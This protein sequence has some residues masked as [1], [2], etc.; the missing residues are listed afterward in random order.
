M[1]RASAL[2]ATQTPLELHP[3]DADQRNLSLG[4]IAGAGDA[5]NALGTGASNALGAALGFHVP[6]RW[7]TRVLPCE[8]TRTVR[9][10]RKRPRSISAAP[11]QFTRSPLR[12][13]SLEATPW[14]RPGRA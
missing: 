3:A 9:R 12:G 13:T 11:V 14:G 1:R 6:S 5:G 2:N 10:I 4:K 7:L 8:S